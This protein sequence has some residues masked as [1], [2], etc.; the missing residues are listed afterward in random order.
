MSVAEWLRVSDFISLAPHR[1]GF[2][3]SGAYESLCEEAIQLAFETSVIR[4]ARKLP[5]RAPGVFLH[6]W[7][8]ESRHMTLAVGATINSISISIHNCDPQGRVNSDYRIII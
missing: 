2:D 3:P 5:G 1:C 7:K 6:Q 8:L 4:L